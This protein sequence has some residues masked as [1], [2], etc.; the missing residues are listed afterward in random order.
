MR[1][2]WLVFLIGFTLI[3]FTPL[4]AFAEE[5]SDIS[6]CY[7]EANTQFELNRCGGTDYATADAEL[8][9]V[10]R[11]IR[12]IYKDNP[13]FLEKMEVAQHAWITFRDAEFDM[14]YP[15]ADEP[16]YYGSVF[17]MCAPQYRTRLTLERVA[18]LKQWLVG[19]EK[20]SVC[21]G[22]VM[23]S[24]YLQ[25]LTCTDNGGEWE[26]KSEACRMP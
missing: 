25:K 19:K 13:V 8:N 23:S 3:G 12:E 1:K 15:H 17:G 7:Q 10:Y 4:A 22:S 16:R 11:Q 9:R 24:L 2:L 6:A 14:K 21:G 18:T 5:N 20:G 26:W